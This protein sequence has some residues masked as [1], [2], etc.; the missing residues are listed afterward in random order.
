MVFFFFFWGGG[1]GGGVQTV[2]SLLQTTQIVSGVCFTAAVMS[3]TPA[4]KYQNRLNQDGTL[5]FYFFTQGGCA[6]CSVT[7]VLGRQVASAV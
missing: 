5:F 3:L 1:G 4:V 2:V 6:S 7:C